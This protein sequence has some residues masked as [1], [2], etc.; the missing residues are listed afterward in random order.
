MISAL[1]LDRGSAPAGIRATSGESGI[2]HI[3]KMPP[4]EFAV[5]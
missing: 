3:A 4:T 5:Y 2:D 1:A